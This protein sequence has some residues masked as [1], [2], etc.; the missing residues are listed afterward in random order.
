MGQGSREILG[1]GSIY[2][3]ATAAPMVAGVVIL[4]IL[5]RRLSISEY[6][7]VAIAIVV[8]QFGTGLAGLGLPTA[9][10]RHALVAESG[11]PGARGLA[12]MGGAIATSLAVVSALGLLAWAALSGTSGMSVFVLALLAA[13]AGAVAANVTAYFLAVK[14][15]WF[16]VR[17]AFGLSFLAP[18][19]GLVVVLIGRATALG[20][21]AGLASVYFVAGTVAILRVLRLKPISLGRA[22][23]RAALRIGLP[24]LPYL[25]SIGL[26][27]GSMVFVGNR[28]FGLDAGAET[29]IAISVGSLSLIVI[30]AIFNAWMPA[31]LATPERERGARL[32][33]TGAD[34]AWLAALGAGGVGVLSPWLLRFVTSSE[35]DQAAMVPV[36]SV[37]GVAACVAAVFF[38][39]IQLVIAAGATGKMAFLSPLSLAAGIGAALLV[40]PYLGLVGLAVGF[41]VMYV[42]LAVATSVMARRTSPSR[43]NHRTVV[44]P[45]LAALALAGLGALL[46]ISGPS[47]LWRIAAAAV[48]VAI[49]IRR[50]YG[51]FRTPLLPHIGLDD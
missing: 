20:Y 42:S 45:L 10:T 25:L 34:V 37:I 23:A 11:P 3:L 47:S 48:I 1:R 30:S 39:N 24:M 19:A 17:I 12:L 51:T 21:L 31:I 33:E 43:W 44:A 50:L 18:A 28:L 38:A 15:A 32:E 49:A 22:D 2:T 6:G 36:V 13:G 41:V 35:Y 40:A 5:T 29:Q 8:M 16:Y 27:S 9:I 26:A 14:D 4:P 7:Y 46:P